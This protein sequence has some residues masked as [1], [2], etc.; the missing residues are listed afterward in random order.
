MPP[1]YKARARSAPGILPAYG[2]SYRC[3]WFHFDLYGLLCVCCRVVRVLLLLWSI[4]I[5]E[6]L[7][8]SLSV[9]LQKEMDVVALYARE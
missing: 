2:W 8:R 7:R 9:C 1:R 3:E 4:D 5:A 6:L